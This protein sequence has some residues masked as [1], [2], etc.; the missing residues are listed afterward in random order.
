MNNNQSKRYKITEKTGSIKDKNKSS[1][2]IS[3]TFKILI[4]IIAYL[5]C[6]GVILGL[7]FTLLY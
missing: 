7:I 1:I 3:K 5:A 6:V 2:H 4:L